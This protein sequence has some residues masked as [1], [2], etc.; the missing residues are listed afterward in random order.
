VDAFA[1][2]SAFPVWAIN[3]ALGFP[4]AL[5]GLEFQAI[6]LHY[7]LF[8]LWP[9]ELNSRFRDYLRRSSACRIAFFQDEH[10]HCEARFAFLRGYRVDVVFTLLEPNEARKIY[11]AHAGVRDTV[12]TLTGY[13]SEDLLRLAAAKYKPDEARG[14]DIGYRARRL[15]YYMGRGAQEKHL[16]GERFLREAATEGLKL[17]IAVGEAERVHGQGWYDFLAD[18]RGVLGVEAGVSVF[19]LDG[20]IERECSRLLV[21][22]PALT[23]DEVHRRVLAPHEGNVY[24]RT[25]SPR[26]FEAAA[27]R[28]CQILYE[29]QYQDI[30]QP[31]VH[32]LC[33]RKDFSNLRDVLAAFRDPE[34]RRRITGRAYDDLIV[35]GRYTYRSFIQEVDAALIGRGINPVSLT[36][37]PSHVQSAL[38]RDL[39]WRHALAVV[40]SL[41]ER[42]FPGRRRAVNMANRLRRLY[43][44]ARATVRRARDT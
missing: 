19:D 17:D 20:S 3:T 38:D 27:F 42:R 8:G 32:Y 44:M 41:P 26:H 7:S 13:V 18:C 6:L 16:I 35:S 4:A 23:F 31:D 39:P 24:Y 21:R 34:A 5:D 40:R 12:T 25:I 37:A 2:H 36:D 1:H 33:L 14:I 15:A 10:H 43:R 29:G 28:V 9:P 22:H 30:L 11:G